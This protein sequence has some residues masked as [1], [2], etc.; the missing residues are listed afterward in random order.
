MKRQP[1]IVFENEVAEVQLVYTSKVKARD[2]LQVCSAQQAAQIFRKGGTKT[3][4]N[5]KKK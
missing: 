3:P 5:Y 2:R 4:C 1:Q